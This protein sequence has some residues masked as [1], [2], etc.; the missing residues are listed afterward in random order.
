MP[1]Q[2]SNN[3]VPIIL[4]SS[5]WNWVG[6]VY[7]KIY[8]TWNTLSKNLKLIQPRLYLNKFGSCVAVQFIPY[9]SI[10][11]TLPSTTDYIWL[12]FLLSQM[13]FNLWDEYQIHPSHLFWKNTP[14]T[15]IAMFICLFLSNNGQK[16][17]MLK[18]KQD[19]ILV[20]MW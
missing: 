7:A 13:K 14:Y 5:H 1:T 2:V 16:Q 19:I 3:S 10:F 18:A 17:D 12:I 6:T 4:N 15:P 11:Y 8:K 20:E 9:K